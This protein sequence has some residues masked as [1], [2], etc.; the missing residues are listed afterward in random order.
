MSSVEK[1]G[2][3]RLCVPDKILAD[4]V[5][6]GIVVHSGFLLRRRHR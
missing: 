1:R 4:D 5:R 6:L 2:L 3:F